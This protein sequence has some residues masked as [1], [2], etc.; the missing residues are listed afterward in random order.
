MQDLWAGHRELLM[1]GIQRQI[2]DATFSSGQLVREQVE[3]SGETGYQA[4]ALACLAAAEAVGGTANAAL[5]AAVAVAYVAQMATVFTGL[6]NSGG[7]PSLSTAWGMPRSLNAGDAMFA[8]AQESLLAEGEEITAEVRLR[9]TSVLDA[10]TRELMEVLIAATM[11]DEEDLQLL[12]QRVLLP[13]AMALGGLLAGGDEDKTAM[14]ERLGQEWSQ[15]EADD[16]WRKLAGAPE[17][18]LA[19]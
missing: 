8:L 2:D 12:T 17:E 18:W 7:A 6:E 10:A 3:A 16:L 9:A 15:L 1:D 4:S 14:L 13:S 5:P 11:T 19:T